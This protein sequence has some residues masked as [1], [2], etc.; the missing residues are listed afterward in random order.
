VHETMQWS[1]TLQVFFK[2]FDFDLPKT[3]TA[4]HDNYSMELR[5]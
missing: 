2:N 4:T 3:P 1:G 5:R